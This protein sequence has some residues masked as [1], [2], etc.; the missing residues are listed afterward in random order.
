MSIPN[1]PKF[2]LSLDPISHFKNSFEEAKK[3]V[4]K[5]PNAV[6][7]ATSTV[8]GVPS[9]RTVLF[10]GLVRGGFSFYTNYES[11][12]SQ[13][14]L[15][16]PRA[17]LLFYWPAFDHQVRIEGVVEKLT[18]EESEAYFKTRGRLSQLG[19]WASHQSQSLLDTDALERRV[20]EFEKQFEGQE[21]PCPL[22]W[23]GFLVQPLLIEFW[24]GKNARLHERY[25]YQRPN[26]SS[27]WQ[28]GMKFP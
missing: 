1:H 26:V 13:E 17:A 18:R 20:Q 27:A 7:L 21:V 19:A 16:N 23:G 8:A 25:V 3:L 14:L 5:D 9:V 6:Y 4:P 28:T 24:F 2:D 11:Q 12:K 10:K 15:A 22:N